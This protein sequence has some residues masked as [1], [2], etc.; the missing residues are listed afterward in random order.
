MRTYGPI[1]KLAVYSQ[2]N[3]SLLGFVDYTSEHVFLWT[4]IGVR[5]SQIEIFPSISKPTS[6][7]PLFLKDFSEHFEGSHE[8]FLEYVY[9]NHS[10]AQN[11]I[12]LLPCCSSECFYTIQ[13][14]V[15]HLLQNNT[16]IPGKIVQSIFHKLSHTYQKKALV[17]MEQSKG[18][19]WEIY[20]EE[21]LKKAS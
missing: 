13:S 2:R 12:A 4:P 16:F 7:I 15:E 17:M 21:P 19:P 9:L 14:A 10:S 8:E 6:E 20:E 11:A 3:Q 1:H 18:V 5:H